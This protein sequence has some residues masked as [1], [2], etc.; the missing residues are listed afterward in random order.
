MLTG[1]GNEVVAVEAMK[2]GVKDYLAKRKLT[3]EI[4]TT[5]IKYVLQQH[6]LQ[7][8]LKGIPKNKHFFL[9]GD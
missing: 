2:G 8:L 5:S 6:R 7:S 1:Q 4:L 3:P 9:F